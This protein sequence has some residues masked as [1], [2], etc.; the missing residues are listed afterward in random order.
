MHHLEFNLDL[1]GC[2]LLICGIGN[3]KKKL[4]VINSTLINARHC[5]FIILIAALNSTKP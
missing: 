5:C 3:N 1:T 4:V 2:D